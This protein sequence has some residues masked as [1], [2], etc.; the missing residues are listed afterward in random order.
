MREALANIIVLALSVAFL[1]HFSFIVIYGSFF[2]Q[3]PNPII[4]SLEI[5]LFI[6]CIGFA[7]ANLIRLWRGS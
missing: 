7:I 6:G 2:I 5:A 3:E 1:F 4:L